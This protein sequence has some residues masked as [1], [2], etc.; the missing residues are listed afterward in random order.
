MASLQ[1]AIREYHRQL[2]RGI[3]QHAYR[4]LM[5]YFGKLR[6]HFK[7]KNPKYG[8]SG[9]ICYGYM[10]MTYFFPLPGNAE[11]M[12]PEDCRSFPA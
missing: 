1:E 4:G 11:T 9:G 7:N 5:N 12:R 10:D 3:I 8:V 6:A 2:E